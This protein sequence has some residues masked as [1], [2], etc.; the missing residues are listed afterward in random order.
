MNY[1]QVLHKCLIL[2]FKNNPNICNFFS[3]KDLHFV[4][5]QAPPPSPLS[6]KMNFL[7]GSTNLKSVKRLS[8]IFR[9]KA[10]YV[11]CRTTNF[12][13]YGTLIPSYKR[14]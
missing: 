12:P 1:F 11:F 14:K 5:G 3:P 2:A 10:Y 7:Y 9:A 13:F 8:S 4:S 6:G